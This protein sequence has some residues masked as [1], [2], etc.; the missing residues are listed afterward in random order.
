MIVYVDASVAL[1][2]LLRQPGRL[3]S[4]ADWDA[5]YSSELLGLEIRRTIDR[6]R[7]Q[8]DLGGEAV[9]ELLQSATMIEE[10]LAVVSLTRTVIQRAGLPMATPVRTLDA[11]HLATALMVRE[12]SA[13][14]LTFVT[15]DVQQAGAARALGFAVA[16]V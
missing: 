7:V 2:V 3:R 11:I 10:G 15:H 9:A 8:G 5:A 4:W 14:P 12:R 16:G 1:R 13:Q 6:L